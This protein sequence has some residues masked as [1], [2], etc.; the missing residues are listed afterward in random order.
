MHH[1]HTLK[2]FGVEDSSRRFQSQREIQRIFER[3]PLCKLV[4]RIKYLTSDL[5]HVTNYESLPHKVEHCFLHIFVNCEHR[6]HEK[7]NLL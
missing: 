3:R 1:Q 6:S 7:E 4:I 2:T 5:R